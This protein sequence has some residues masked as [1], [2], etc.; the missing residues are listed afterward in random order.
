[1]SVDDL[2]PNL[3]EL[4]DDEQA[5]PDPAVSA[6]RRRRLWRALII[7]AAVA[8]VIAASIGAVRAAGRHAREAVE[9][10]G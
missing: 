3:S 2:L 6:A 8:L 5:T 10:L 4:F 1:M 9:P 7:V